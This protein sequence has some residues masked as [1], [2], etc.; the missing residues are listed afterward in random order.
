MSDLKNQ[1][2]SKVQIF[3]QLISNQVNVTFFFPCWFLVG[4]GVFLVMQ[5]LIIWI[6]FMA[7][8]N[9]QTNKETTKRKITVS[10][11]WLTAN[12]AKAFRLAY[13]HCNSTQKYTHAAA[14]SQGEWQTF[15]LVDSTGLK[16]NK[17]IYRTVVHA[18]NQLRNII[19]LWETAVVHFPFL[20][21]ILTYIQA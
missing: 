3:L 17:S 9:K 7:T 21:R 10:F 19:Q 18:F 4:F 8:E 20:H 6:T 12:I 13:K 15:L 14:S 11:I 1:C 2:C 16:S 5:W